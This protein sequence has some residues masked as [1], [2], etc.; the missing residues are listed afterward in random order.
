[1]PCSKLCYGT[2]LA[3]KVESELWRASVV[4][5][6]LTVLA[7]ILSSSRHIHRLLTWPMVELC[8]E[9]RRSSAI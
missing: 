7:A 6:L 4:H 5:L 1:M 3:N 9:P 2:L 8:T